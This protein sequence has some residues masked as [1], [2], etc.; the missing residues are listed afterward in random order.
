MYTASGSKKYEEGE[1]V[2]KNDIVLGLS[3]VSLY[4]SNI[5]EKEYS[6]TVEK[7]CNEIT[8]LRSEIDRLKAEQPKKGHWIIKPIEKGNVT[9]YVFRCSEC[10]SAEEHAYADCWVGNFCK[11]CGAD[12]KDGDQDDN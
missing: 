4:L 3:E 12:L 11:W 7:S 1:K 2:D 10:G 8:E 5:G 9:N 6:E